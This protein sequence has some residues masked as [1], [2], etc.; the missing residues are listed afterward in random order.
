MWYYSQTDI[1]LCGYA[2]RSGFLSA[3]LI[4]HTGYDVCMT[5]M[6]LF[7][8]KLLCGMLTEAASYWCWGVPMLMRG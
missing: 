2:Y 6:Q 4:R 7:A 5:S 8:D 3:C 1:V